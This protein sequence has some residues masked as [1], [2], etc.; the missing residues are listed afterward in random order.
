[1]RGDCFPG[2]DFT[3]HDTEG[4]F[5]DAPVDAGDGFVVRWSE[6]V[7]N[8]GRSG[9]CSG[10]VPSVDVVVEVAVEDAGSYL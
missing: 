7:T 1:M 5:I 4:L 2:A 9:C 8:R 10:L 3:S 6:T